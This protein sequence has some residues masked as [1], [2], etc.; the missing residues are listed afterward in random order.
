MQQKDRTKPPLYGIKPP[1]RRF[2]AQTSPT[3]RFSFLKQIRKLR[4]KRRRRLRKAMARR[5]GRSGMIFSGIVFVLI[6]IVTFILLG[7]VS[8]SLEGALTHLARLDQW[9]IETAQSVAPIDRLFEPEILGTVQALHEF[10]QT[11]QGMPFIEQF[12]GTEQLQNTTQLTGQWRE[13]IHN[14]Q[15]PLISSIHRFQQLIHIWQSIL[16]ALQKWLGVGVILIAFLLSFLCAWSAAAQ[17]ALY[18]WATREK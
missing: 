12:I 13:A 1:Y 18:R 5:L 8:H 17:W 11:L 14:R 15:T 3:R 6:W 4:K 16:L 10:S 9:A 2:V 7:P